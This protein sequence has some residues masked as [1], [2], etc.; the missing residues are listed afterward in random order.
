MSTIYEI[1]FP[2]WPIWWCIFA[3]SIVYAYLLQLWANKWPESFDDNTWLT[4]VIGDGYVVLWLGA[5]ISFDAWAKL[6][7]ALLVACIPIVY[8]SVRGARG[9]R[10]RER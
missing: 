8:R 10:G 6:C 9:Q 5:I 3:T 4:V 1:L 7:A 2:H